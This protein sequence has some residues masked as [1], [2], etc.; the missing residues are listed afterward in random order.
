MKPAGFVGKWRIIHMDDFTKKDIDM[1]VPAFIDVER[2]GCG[3]FQFILVRGAM[4]GDFK[5]NEIFDFTW[6]GGDDCDE[7]S[8]DG[9]MKLR[10]GGTAAE[11]EIRFH[12]GDTHKFR[13]VKKPKKNKAVRRVGG[14][15]RAVLKK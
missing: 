4:C 3:E 10:P 1:E 5:N 13:A 6:E 14:S 9:W 12:C 8:G 7:A 11:G 2:G 15:R